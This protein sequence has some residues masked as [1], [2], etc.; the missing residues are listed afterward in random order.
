MTE[1]QPAR[2]LL[3]WR[4]RGSLVTADGRCLSEIVDQL[5]DALG[6]LVADLT[7]P[8]D[9]LTG[10]VGQLPVDVLLA[11]DERALI[12]AAHRHDNVRLPGELGREQPWGAVAE[13][14]VELAHHSHDLGMDV[15]GRRRAG[16]ER[17]VGVPGGAFEQ[18]LA[19]LGASGVVPADEQDGSHA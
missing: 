14:D 8:F 12:P 19:D 18:R 13:F 2:P 9:W 6:D 7:D 3:E 17:P 10:G 4:R 5:R 16:R 1:Q 11:R 15:V